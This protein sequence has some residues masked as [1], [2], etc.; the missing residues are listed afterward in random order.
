MPN[1][2]NKS[3]QPDLIANEALIVLQNRLGISNRVHVGFD[4]ERRAFNKGEYVRIRR[5]QAFT[6]TTEPSS[7]TDLAPDEVTIQVPNHQGV[8][9]ALTDK[10]AAY[11]GPEQTN[12]VI[13]EHVAPAAAAIAEA[14]ENSLWGLAFSTPYVSSYTVSSMTQ[15]AIVDLRTQLVNNKMPAGASP[16]DLTLACSPATYARF[17]KQSAFTQNQGAGLEGVATQSTAQIQAKYG[18]GFLESQLAPTGA[19]DGVTT[20]TTPTVTGAHVKGATSIV[21]AGASMSGTFRKGQV[22]TIAGQRYAITADQAVASNSATVSF[23][24]PL[25]AD[26]AGGAVWALVSTATGAYRADLAFHRHAMG[27]VMARLPDDLIRQA[28][29]AVASIQDPQTGLAIRFRM[30]YDGANNKLIAAFDALW[31]VQMLN[32]ALCIRGIGL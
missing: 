7:A 6:A 9:F 22:F 15:D 20:V 12:L 26:V 8:R 4:A 3:W 13:A 24:P 11:T 19:T 14:I 1:V 29:V 25:K 17:L 27:L 30:Y 28:G 31:G 2:F 5:P 32:E 21:L 18:F 16:N 10:E 23:Y